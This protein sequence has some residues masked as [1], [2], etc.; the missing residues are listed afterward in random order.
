MVYA[1]AAVVVLVVLAGVGWLIWPRQSAPKLSGTEALA[2]LEAL[3]DP[4]TLDVVPAGTTF[5]A[6]GVRAV[7]SPSSDGEPPTAWTEYDLEGGPID[8]AVDELTSRF[9]ETGWNTADDSTADDVRIVNL[10]RP[11]AI[12]GRAELT[13]EHDHVAVSVSLDFE[14]ACYGP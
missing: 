9:E 5:G 11:G 12:R 10:D 1:L 13:A 14:D 6:D 4:L 8:G 2:Q 7:C 3:T